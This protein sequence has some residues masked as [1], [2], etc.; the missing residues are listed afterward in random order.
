MSSSRAVQVER[1]VAAAPERVWD[2][3]AEVTEMGRW[4]PEATNAVWVG[5]AHGPALGARFKGTN[6]M[7]S[8]SWKSDCVVTACERGR[9]F[10]F[11]VKA[12]PFKVAGWTYE[13]VPVEGGCRVTESWEDH[14]GLLVTWLSPLITGTKDRAKRNQ[15]TMM[16][17]LQRLATAVEAT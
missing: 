3:V 12:G 4:S 15:E 14:R 13:F 9:R 7:G 5:G 2:L 8:K 11:D 10:A 16:A 17:T 6:Q 1:T